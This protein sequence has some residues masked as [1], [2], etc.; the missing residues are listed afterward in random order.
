MKEFIQ[1]NAKKI[2]R[3]LKLYHLSKEQL[4]QKLGLTKKDF[5]LLMHN[6]LKIK[7]SLAIR[8]QILFNIPAEFWI[9]NK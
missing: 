9:N 4:R 3:L 5:K 1:D 2:K 7:Q 8:L 6:K